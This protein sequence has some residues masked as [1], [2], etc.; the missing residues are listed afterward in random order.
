MLDI[1]DRQCAQLL[2][3]PLVSLEPQYAGVKHL[4]YIPYTPYAF[5]IID[6]LISI[7][8]LPTLSVM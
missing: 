3:Y 4:S 6:F 2:L 5:L 7:D 8:L 1:R